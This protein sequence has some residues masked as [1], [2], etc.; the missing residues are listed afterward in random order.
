MGGHI[1]YNIFFSFLF[2]HSNLGI[3]G[4]WAFHIGSTS[5]LDNVRP[6]TVGGDLSK[7][8]PSAPLGQ[9]FS[10]AVALEDDYTQ[11]PL[12]DYDEN[13]EEIEYPPSEP[14]EASNGYSSVD[15]SLRGRISAPDSDLASPVP[16]SASQ[17]G[18]ESESSP[19][20]PHTKERR[21]Q[22]ETDAS[23]LKGRVESSEQPGTRV[24]AP[25]ETEG[26]SPAPP[27]EAPPPSPEGGAGPADQDALPAHPGGE[28]ALPNY[29]GPD[30]TPHLGHRR[31]VVGVEDDI[32]SNT[33]GKWI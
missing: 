9:S 5:S 10:H 14:A 33:E 24:P 6:A 25:P 30:H 32:S 18:L 17:G 16:R 19:L 12:D 26:E 7:A 22:G 13:E 2:R 29:P 31:Q 15:V 21:P 11:D 3:P 27:G 28:A 4:V 20:D 8:R 23:D 1:C